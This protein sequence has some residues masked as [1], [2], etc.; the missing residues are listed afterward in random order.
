MDD[1]RIPPAVTF[2]FEQ[3]VS[4]VCDE[5]KVDYGERPFVARELNNHL[6]DLWRRGIEASMSTDDA[7]AAAI[8][9]FGRLEDVARSLRQPFWRRLLFYERYQAARYI[10]FLV[11]GTI[12][13]YACA[14]NVMDGQKTTENARMVALGYTL[15]P[16]FATMSLLAI[17]WTPRNLILKILAVPRYLLFA[18]VLTGLFNVVVTPG[19]M[20]FGDLKAEGFYRFISDPIGCVIFVLGILGGWIAAACFVSELFGLAQRS[21]RKRVRA[22]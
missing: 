2:A 9:S 19:M 8:V 10:V 22:T 16:A 3:I 12:I 17:R 4:R 20:C 14:V 7:Q 6:Q 21:A 5:A 13:N 1:L 15:N 11:M 18:V